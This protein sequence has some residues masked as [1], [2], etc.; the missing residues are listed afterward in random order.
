LHTSSEADLKKTGLI[1]SGFR[2]FIECVIENSRTV[3]AEV[4]EK[5]YDHVDCK[6]AV[7]ALHAQPEMLLKIAHEVK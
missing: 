6:F 4:I 2:Y 1:S 5:A 3:V 7:K